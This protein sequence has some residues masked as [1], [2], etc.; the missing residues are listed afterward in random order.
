MDLWT[1]DRH[2]C[3]FPIAVDLDLNLKGCLMGS[4]IHLAPS[5]GTWIAAFNLNKLR[6]FLNS[7]V[8]MADFSKN[9]KPL[10]MV[11]AGY[12]PNRKQNLLD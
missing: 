6:S 2:K 5:R 10:N 8:T 12:P 7:A 4:Q 3:F 1:M 9:V 11:T